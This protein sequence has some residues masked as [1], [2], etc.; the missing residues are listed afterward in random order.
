MSMDNDDAD[1]LAQFDAF[2]A[3]QAEEREQQE[4][5]SAYTHPAPGPGPEGDGGYGHPGLVPQPEGGYGLPGQEPEGD[6]GHPR[7]VPQP[8]GGYTFPPEYAADPNAVYLPLM[9]AT[10]PPGGDRGRRTRSVLI[11]GGAVLV[12]CVLA[13]GAWLAFGSSSSSANAA[14]T[15]PAA[16][17]TSTAAAPGGGADTAKRALTFRVTI[18]S[19]GSDSFT[20]K[21]LANGDPVTVTMTSSTRFGTQAHA[22]DRSDLAVGETVIVRGRRTG[23]DTVTATEV[24]ANVASTS[25]K[26]GTATA[27]TTG[28]GA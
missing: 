2:R 21:A 27:T 1:P 7:Q 24:A 3:R 8:E 11:F 25:T 26:K 23:T 16:T 22:F 9:P 12:I 5:Q 20:G 18:V 13:L 10:A 28:N 14:S 4:T 6:Y 19:L 17:T 15:G